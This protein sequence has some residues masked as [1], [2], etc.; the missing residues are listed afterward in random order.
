VAGDTLA[1]SLLRIRAG[2]TLQDQIVLFVAQLGL[3][4]LQDLRQKD[5]PLDGLCAFPTRLGRSSGRRAAGV[6]ELFSMAGL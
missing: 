4:L 5:T 1:I 3:R 2:R 6:A